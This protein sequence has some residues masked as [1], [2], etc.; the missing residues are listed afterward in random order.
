VFDRFWRGRQA[1]QI[2]GSGIGLAVAS[3]L[4]RAHGGQLAASSEPGQG[5]EMTL[6]LPRA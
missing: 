3:E 2:S 1:A 4:A 5:T 6:T